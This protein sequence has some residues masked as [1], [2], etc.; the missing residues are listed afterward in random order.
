VRI[1]RTGKAKLALY[2][3]GLREAEHIPTGWAP[4]KKGH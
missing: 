4:M 3:R 1:S 2:G